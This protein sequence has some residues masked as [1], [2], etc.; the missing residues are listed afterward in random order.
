MLLLFGSAGSGSWGLGTGMC[1]LL[2]AASRLGICWMLTEQ[3]PIVSLD[4]PLLKK[5][6]ETLFVSRMVVPHDVQLPG[7]VAS[8]GVGWGLAAPR[9][10]E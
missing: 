8:G 6:P 5:G 4:V 3:V 7:T 10:V 9:G 2:A 1:A